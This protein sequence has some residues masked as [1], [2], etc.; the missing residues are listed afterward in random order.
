MDE[1]LDENIELIDNINNLDKYYLSMSYSIIYSGYHDYYVIVGKLKDNHYL[2]LSII[3]YGKDV[4]III[5][6][7]KIWRLYGYG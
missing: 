7:S 4:S 6:I 2:Y 1:S 5:K 3:K